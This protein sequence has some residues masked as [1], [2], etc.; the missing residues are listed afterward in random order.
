MA[1]LQRKDKDKA[2]LRL[3]VQPSPPPPPPFL[4]L[5]FFFF[6]P[7]LSLFSF[8]PPFP[9]A[10]VRWGRDGKDLGGGRKQLSFCWP[11]L[12]WRP[13]DTVARKCNASASSDNTPPSSLSLLSLLPSSVAPS[14]FLFL[15]LPLLLLLLLLL[16]VCL[17]CCSVLWYPRL[18]PSSS[19]SPSPAFERMRMMSVRARSRSW[20][21]LGG[22]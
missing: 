5:L 13:L 11:P 17:G 6:P 14:S 2:F 22:R 16:P 4:P 19:W 21:R 18:P 20:S 3:I 8:P 10:P 12:L 1:S 15:L 9:S 7:T